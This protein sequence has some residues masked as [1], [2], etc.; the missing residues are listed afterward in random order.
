MNQVITI[1][2]PPGAYGSFMSWTVDRFSRIR[3]SMDRSVADDPLSNDG[4]S[5]AHAS[6]CSI[7][8]LEGFITDLD[9]ARSKMVPWKHAVHAGWPVRDGTSVDDAIESVLSWMS[10]YDKLITIEP[11]DADMHYICYLR[12]EA[13]LDRDR[14]QSMTGIDP[15]DVTSLAKQLDA[16][17]SRQRSTAMDGEPRWLR[18]GIGNILNYNTEPQLFDMIARHLAWPVVDKDLFVET[19]RRMRG[20]QQRFFAGMVQA[21]QGNGTT[22][23]QRAIHMVHS[24]RKA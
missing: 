12:S 22:P 14:W 24:K 10:P 9:D 20:M 1:L 23:V 16:D 17:I 21:K 11:T 13:T 6:H 19:C 8:T 15:G 5:H 4:S 18:L 7:D 3:R 2:Y